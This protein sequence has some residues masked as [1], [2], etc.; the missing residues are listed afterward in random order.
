M[1][2]RATIRLGIGPHSSYF[3]NHRSSLQ[4]RDIEYQAVW[5]GSQQQAA[6][7][8]CFIVVATVEHL[9]SAS[10]KFIMSVT[11]H[12]YTRRIFPRIFSHTI[13]FYERI[14]TLAIL[15]GKTEDNRSQCKSATL[16]Q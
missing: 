9:K 1:F 4:K 10:N 2:G 7:A 5:T 12:K 8:F 6:T 13:Y 16:L 3:V 11:M 14:Q 15:C